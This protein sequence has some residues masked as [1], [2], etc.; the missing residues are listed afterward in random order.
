MNLRKTSA[1]IVL[2]GL[3]AAGGAAQEAEPPLR[4]GMIGLDTSHVIAF[5]QLLNDPKN[6]HHVPGAR[7]VCG[8]KGGSPD[9]EASRTRVDNF[10]RQLQEKFGV[11]IV[12]SIEALCRKVDAVLIM[13]VDGRPHLE[14]A[15]AVFAA[16]KRLFIDK[17]LAGSLRDAREI[18]RLA[19]ESNTPFFSASSLRFADSVARTRTDPALGKILGCDAF[20]PA[21]REP[22]HP[23]L[24]WYGVHGVEILF[25]VLGPGCESVRRVETPEADFVVGRWKDGRVGTFRGLRKGHSG[26]GA[27]VFGE[28]AVRSTLSPQA[29]AAWAREARKAGAAVDVPEIQDSY[30]NLVREI[31][32]FFRTGRPPVP[33]EEMLE[34]LAFMEAADVS[35]SRGGAEVRLAELP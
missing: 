3:L 19:R 8:F 17:P 1:G 34:V 15:R 5:T 25:S 35:K 26:F 30:R 29:V 14:Q 13:S 27:T 10:T 9:V 22:H 28:K 32:A 33:V 7:V 11:E 2:L 24:F 6:P 23:D 31:V 18:A 21:S 20:S 16:G 4:L 12:D